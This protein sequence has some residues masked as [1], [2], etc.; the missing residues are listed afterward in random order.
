MGA[1]HKHFDGA[2]DDT[3]LR[4]RGFFVLNADGLCLGDERG[5]FWRSRMG[6]A[7]DGSG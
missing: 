7:A 6:R 4:Q 1:C 3:N 5:S 2:L